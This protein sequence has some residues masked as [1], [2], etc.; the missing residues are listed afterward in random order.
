[1]SKVKTLIV[2]FLAAVT[3]ISAVNASNFKLT[4]EDVDETYT[5]TQYTFQNKEECAASSNAIHIAAYEKIDLNVYKNYQQVTMTGFYI[6]KYENG[7]FTSAS[8]KLIKTVAR[9]TENFSLKEAGTYVFQ[10]KSSETDPSGY[11][12]YLY[13]KVIVS[14]AYANGPISVKISTSGQSVLSGKPSAAA[15]DSITAFYASVN[16]VYNLYTDGSNL[17]DFTFSVRTATDGTA[18]SG[19]YDLNYSYPYTSNKRSATIKFKQAGTYYI[20]SRAS[21]G[22]MEYMFSLPAYVKVIVQ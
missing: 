1:M 17:Q 7:S 18:Y 9:G 12:P 5:S 22:W 19:Y 8:N 14:T 3:S 21:S 15:A 2:G 20:R 4:M 6:W 16:S 13:G 10:C 11:N